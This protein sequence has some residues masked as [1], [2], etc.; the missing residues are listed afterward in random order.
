MHVDTKTSLTQFSRFVHEMAWSEV[1]SREKTIIKE[2]KRRKD[3]ETSV[4]INCCL[5]TVLRF[6]ITK[7]RSQY[8]SR[9][10]NVGI[11]Q[12]EN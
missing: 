9:L 2:H 11:G 8:I 1:M 7:Q 12:Y 4:I 5:N 10:E 6:F 3:T